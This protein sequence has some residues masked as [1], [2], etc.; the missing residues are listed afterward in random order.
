LP[1]DGRTAEAHVYERVY[2]D[3]IA[4]LGG[5]SRT[6]EAQ[7][8]LALRAT[9]LSIECK[10]MEARMGTGDPVPMSEYNASV[11]TLNRL[12]KAMRDAGPAA[13]LPEMNTLSPGMATARVYREALDPYYGLRQYLEEAG[14]R[15]TA[16]V[17]LTPEALARLDGQLAQKRKD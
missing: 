15:K 9:A 3:F 13:Q 1:V 4:D 5:P 2:N 12:L 7:H 6:T 8:Q 10:K 11:N 14:T 17:Q 16:R